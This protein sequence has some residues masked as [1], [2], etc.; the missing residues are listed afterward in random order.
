MRKIFTIIAMAINILMFVSASS[1]LV[2]S[3]I[4]N[5]WELVACLMLLTGTGLSVILFLTSL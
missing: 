5:K 3:N 1:G 2:T 4:K